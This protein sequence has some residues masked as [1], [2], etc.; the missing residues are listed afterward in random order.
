MITSYKGDK[1]LELVQLLEKKEFYEQIILR[2][3]YMPGFELAES[4]YSVLPSHRFFWKKNP[5][6]FEL[7]CCTCMAIVET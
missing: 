2:V 4:G 5:L 7:K 6:T 1:P 3:F